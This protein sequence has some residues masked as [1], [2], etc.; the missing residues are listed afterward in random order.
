MDT[1][2]QLARHVLAAWLDDVPD[3]VRHEAR[4]ALVNF[5]GCAL[6][7]ST[8]SAMDIAIRALGPY[9]GLP[10]AIAIGRAERYDPLF[11]SLL[12]GISSHVHDYDDTT[13]ANYIHPTSPVASALFAYA[14]VT[15]VR[16]DDFLNAFILGFDVVSRIGNATYPAHYDAGW[17]STGSVGVFG[18][19]VAVGRL[20]GLTEEQMVWAIGLAATQAA[21]IREMFGSMAKSFHPGRSAQ[22]GYMAALLAREGFTSGVHG[23]EGPRGFAAVLSARYD[24][25][26][27]TDGLGTDYEL[28]VNTYKPFPCGIVT[29]PTIDACIQLRAEHAIDAAD[30]DAVRLRVA[31][32]VKDLCDKKHISRGLEGKFSAY[33]AAAIGLG[34]GRA[35]LAEFSD[36]AVN[37]PLLRGLRER[38]ESIGDPAVS[39]DGVVVE[40]TLKDGRTLT[41]VLEASIG[42]LKR[43]LTD[44]Q[45]ETKFRDQA[46]VLPADRVDALIARCWTIDGLDDVGPLLALAV[47]AA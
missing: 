30:V 6:G 39:E 36:E 37:D 2:R 3:D 44:A 14:S 12:N 19:A 23:L 9:T 40:V 32:L 43:P 11:A 29:H 21:G 47:P 13:P 45:L 1:T 15:P 8:H 41:K 16:G 22:S 42:N 18:A 46:T 24:L 25:S 31:P 38:V 10:T 5:V 27:V 35:G 33:H 20:L 4:R 34:R 28:R 26:K 17:H 7:G